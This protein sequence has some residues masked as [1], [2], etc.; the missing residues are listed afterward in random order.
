MLVWTLVV[1]PVALAQAQPKD[2]GDDVYVV[3][4]GDTCGTIGR[5]LFGDAGKGSATLHALNKMGPPP[6]DLEPGTVLRVRGDPDARLT[7]IKPEVNS[8]RAGKPDWFQ[9]NTGQGLWR[10]DSVNTLRQA[11]AEVTFR[12]LTRLQMNENALV[13]IYGQD[14]PCLLY[15]SD[16]ADE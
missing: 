2:A 9:A 10:L 14:T 7:F 11:G 6:H 15:T 3:Q 16:A 13:V 4:P 1:G 5:K 8:K 12:D